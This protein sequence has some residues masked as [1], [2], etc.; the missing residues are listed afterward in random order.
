VP[1][2]RLGDGAICGSCKQRLFAAHP[3]ELTMANFDAQ[4]GKSDIPVVVDFW[5]PW[6][7]PCLSMAPHFA[8][9]AAELEP[10]M[11]LAKLDTE[12]AQDIAG[13]YGIRSI[14]TMI[15]F[16]GGREIAR[17]SGAMDARA[18]VEWLK[19]MAGATQP[20]A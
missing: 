16:Q 5:A 9:A 1:E 18:I 13:R 12:S 2:P 17:R 8:K 6:C 19:P 4:I 7:S 14:P 3:I 11:R 10:R 15:V 20:G